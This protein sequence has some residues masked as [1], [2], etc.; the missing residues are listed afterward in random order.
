MTF[1]FANPFRSAQPVVRRLP[2]D[3]AIQMAKTGDIT[4]LDVRDQKEIARTGKASGALHIP[5]FLLKQKA[6]PRHPEFHPDLKTDK[7]VAIY[8]ATGARS[9]MARRVMAGLGF[10]E[11]YNIGGLTH[12]QSAGGSCEA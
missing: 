10:D 4:V 9:E 12:W 11:V 7:P 6:D 1:G 2:V 8:C 5:L 3:Q